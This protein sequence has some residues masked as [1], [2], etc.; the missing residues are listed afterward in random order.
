MSLMRLIITRK[1]HGVVHMVM[2]RS[3]HFPKTPYLP[4]IVQSRDAC[5][6]AVELQSQGSRLKSNLAMASIYPMLCATISTLHQQ[7]KVKKTVHAACAR[8]F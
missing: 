8:I 7:Y 2:S 4:L 1:W 5:T 3:F 6:S